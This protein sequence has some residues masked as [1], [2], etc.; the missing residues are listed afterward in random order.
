MKS[1]RVLITSPPLGLTRVGL[2]AISAVQANPA[3]PG[4]EGSRLVSSVSWDRFTRP[5]LL[6]SGF[7]IAFRSISTARER[8]S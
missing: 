6:G 5:M 7:A 4:V 2:G 3:I 8:A 1:A